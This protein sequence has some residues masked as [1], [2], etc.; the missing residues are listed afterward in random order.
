MAFQGEYF[1]ERY[2]T[3]AAEATPPIKRMM[4]AGLPVGAGTDATRVASYNPWVSLS[5]LVTSKTVGGLAL[6]PVRNRLDR[7]TAL[8][9]WTEK[10][11]W[12]SNEVGKKGQI[13]AGQ[14]ADLALLSDDYF[15]VPEDEIAHLRSVLTVLGG[16]IV[17][18]EGDYG[19]LGPQA[20]KAMPDWSP[21]ATFGGY[22]RKEETAKK[23]ASACGCASSCTVHGHDHAAALGAQVPAADVQ[24]FW[25]SLGCGCWAV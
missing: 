18:G 15:T 14:L 25:G 24:S 7:E 10:N 22:Y 23:L 1:V 21:V 16:K 8:R 17:Y 9:L 6:Y 4:A 20:P 2:G 3:K 5:W 11:T 19:P 12:F 13:K